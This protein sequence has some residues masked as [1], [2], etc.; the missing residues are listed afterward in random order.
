MGA[1]KGLIVVK[2]ENHQTTPANLSVVANHVKKV[3]YTYPLLLVNL[4]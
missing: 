2:W 1:I 4:N 3:K